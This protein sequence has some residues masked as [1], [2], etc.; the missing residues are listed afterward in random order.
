METSMAS[1]Y[2]D[3]PALNHIITILIDARRLYA[4]A[5]A[6]A[7]DPDAVLNIQKTRD[8][9]TALLA[10]MRGRVRELGGRPVEDGSMLGAAHTAFLNMR[11]VF[12]RDLKVA[13]E[14]VER[15][16]KYLRDEIRKCMRREDLSAET[17]AF[18]GVAL[19]RAVTGEMR[20]EGKRE[21]AA[22]ELRH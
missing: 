14:E 22:Q 15:G 4:R 2:A 9:R 7:K 1:Q 5:L 16:E 11:S 6:L 13:L 21:E 10:T 19:D 12:D 3:I 18:L 17:R 8:E 20:I